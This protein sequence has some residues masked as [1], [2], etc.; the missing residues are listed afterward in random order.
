MNIRIPGTTQLTQP[1]HSRRGT[2]VSN[3]N[4]DRRL[5]SPVRKREARQQ[6]KKGI[7]QRLRLAWTPPGQENQIDEI[8]LPPS[9]PTKTQNFTAGMLGVQGNWVSWFGTRE[10]ERAYRQGWGQCCR[11]AAGSDGRR[12]STATRARSWCPT[13]LLLLPPHPPHP[14]MKTTPPLLS[15]GR[16]IGCS[17]ELGT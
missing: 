13:S 11:R 2:T 6:C 8:A 17:A 5:Q 10:R 12:H 1:A 15:H 7:H 4:E 3:S 14:P 9:N 16:I